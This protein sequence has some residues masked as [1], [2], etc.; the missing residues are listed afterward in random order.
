MNSEFIDLSD[1]VILL[2]IKLDKKIIFSKHIDNLCC[3]AQDKLHP[4]RRMREFL[5]VERAKFLA[6]SLIATQFNY[7]LLIC[8]FFKKTC[9]PM[10]YEKSLI[11]RLT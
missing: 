1:N 3:N 11:K 6:C 4:L 8:M 10:K 9:Y 7:A 5:L 2:G